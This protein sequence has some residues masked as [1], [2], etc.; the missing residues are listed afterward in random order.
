MLVQ[1]SD[2][3][4]DMLRLAEVK[5]LI[6]FGGKYELYQR[7][8]I[9][10]VCILVLGDSLLRMGRFLPSDSSLPAKNKWNLFGS[11]LAYFNLKYHIRHNSFSIA[12]I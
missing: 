4:T 12:H 6:D 8:M 11:I 10:N 2:N 7:G 3:L 1:E 5:I 9:K